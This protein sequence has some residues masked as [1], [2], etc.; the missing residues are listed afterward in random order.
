MAIDK[1][2]GNGG[3]GA[4]YKTSGSKNSGDLQA[5]LTALDN[6]QAI[7]EFDLEGNVLTANRNFLKILGY[8]LN[9]FVACMYYGSLQKRL[10]SQLV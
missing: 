6:I 5:K 9:N 8:D 1:E 2:V 4:T 7:I 10:L 3:S